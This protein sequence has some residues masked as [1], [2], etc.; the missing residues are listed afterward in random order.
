MG[1]DGRPGASL[2]G[3]AEWLPNA[4]IYGADI[5]R[6]VLFQE[7]RIRT[8]Y[9]DQRSPADIANMWDAVGKS[10]LFDVI[11]DDGLHEAAANDTFL[12]A[13]Y[14]KL[15][16]GGIYI[17]E[18]VIDYEIDGIWK[19]IEKYRQLFRVIEMIEIPHD[20]NARDNR[21]VVLHK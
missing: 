8:F 13:S 6:E 2:R 18:D 1:P 14:Q 17:I 7:G 10:I 16:E 5:E 11:I 9:V 15:K 19:L 20:H 4:D 3:W 12:S 21:L